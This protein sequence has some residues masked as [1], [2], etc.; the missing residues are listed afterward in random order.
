[1]DYSYGNDGRMNDGR[2][3]APMSRMD[4]SDYSSRYEV[5]GSRDMGLRTP[6]QRAEVDNSPVVDMET[7]E[8]D[9]GF[10]NDSG[11]ENSSGST[12]G[13]SYSGY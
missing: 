2:M 1:M 9:Y 5:N 10:D 8:V 11:F 12:G 7:I 4:R 6:G 13:S 3:N